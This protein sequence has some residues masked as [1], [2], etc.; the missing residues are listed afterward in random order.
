MERKLFLIILMLCCSLFIAGCW[1]SR[2]IDQLAFVMGI[3]LDKTQEG[4]IKITVQVAKP[5]TFSKSPSGGSDNE[6][7][8]WVASSEGKTIFEAIRNMATFSSRRIFWAHNKVI[9]IGEKMARDDI[10][11]ILDF[12]CRNPEL[13]LRTWIAVTPGEAGKI[14]EREP[15]MEKDPSSAI[16]N[17]INQTVWTGKC[18]R[19]MLKDFLE[20]YL[21]TATYPV[22]ARIVSKDDSSNIKMSGSAVFNQNKLA[23]WLNEKETRGLLWLKG[24]LSSSIMVIPCPLDGRPLSIELIGSKAD[25]KSEFDGQIPRFTVDALASGNLSEQA[26]QTDFT[27][28]DNL[29]KLEKALASAIKD[30]LESVTKAAQTGIG[31][32]FPG[33]NHYL[34]RQH[35]DRWHELVEKWPGLFKKADIIIHVKAMIPR[36]TLFA[37]PLNPVKH[38]NV[39]KIRIEASNEITR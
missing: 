24:Q 26:C 4:N 8:F 33:Y 14:L 19:V 23:G 3:G 21:S 18:Y 16:E 34:H 25:I 22:A 20:D 37:R 36:E 1:N 35:K 32:D 13:R 7:S 2:E 38:N 5:S 17:V 31:L 28:M 30:D 27:N 6:K 39:N 29:R 11:E 15:G 9:I 12:F 10:S